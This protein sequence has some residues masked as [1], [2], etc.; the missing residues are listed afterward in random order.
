MTNKINI[1]KHFTLPT[2]KLVSALMFSGGLAA[3]AV[4]PEYHAPVPA[5][6]HLANT[7]TADFNT[8]SIERN[9]WAQLD[10][11]EL[12]SLIDQG[13]NANHDLRIALA[14]VNAAR[15]QFDISEINRWPV[16]TANGQVTRQMAQQ[17]G[18]TTNRVLTND[19]QVGFDAGWEL[20]IWGRLSSLETAARSRAEAAAFG[21]DQVRV[22][23][24]AE[25]GRNYYLMRGAQQ[26][27][28]VAQRN[29]KN[30]Q[31]TLDITQARVTNGQGT[32]LD[33]A[34]ARA[35]LANVQATLPPLE[36]VV[37]L[38]QYR[39]AV[40]VGV[41]PGTLDAQLA[42]AVLP[43]ISK[44]LPIG[45]AAEL[46]RRRPDIA[47][48]ERELAAA[49]ADVGAAMAERFPRISLGG[50]LGF[51]ASRGGD[52]GQASSKAWSITPSID[53]PAFRLGAVN[54]QVRSN[55]AVVDADVARYEQTVLQAVEETEGALLTY[56]RTQQRLSRLV[57]SAQQSKRAA[58][59]AR[60]R[61]KEGAADFLTLLDAERT[62]LSAEDAMAQAESDSYIELVAVYKALGGG[63]AP[64]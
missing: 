60:V 58:D 14:R 46:I 51:I 35:N 4:G 63:W 42:P 54:A 20:D 8:S 24:V 43:P 23:V 44:P 45:D 6:I 52:L 38:T 50:F 31:S 17:P 48:A 1:V 21:L 55:K 11:P 33:V 49:N 40:L 62:Q 18:F 61:Y 27:Y 57:E 32:E 3:C 9:W 26:R 25:I 10:D 37:K 16:V 59:I 36:T 64:V 53:W 5:E 13:L 7:A 30:L 47:V 19:W 15:A 34:R 2:L 29:L 12:N 56:N 39:L 41:M 28:A 22:S